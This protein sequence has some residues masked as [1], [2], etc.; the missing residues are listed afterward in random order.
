MQMWQGE[1]S[2]GADVA[3]GEPGPGADVA[4]GEP[5]PD[6]DVVRDSERGTCFLDAGVGCLLHGGEQILVPKWNGSVGRYGD[7]PWAPLHW[8]VRA[9]RLYI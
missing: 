1:P 6:A 4:G 2:P 3:G 5:S 7:R 8:R 9:D